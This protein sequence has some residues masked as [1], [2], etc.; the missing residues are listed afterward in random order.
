MKENVLLVKLIRLVM[1]ALFTA[2]FVVLER[3]LS[4]NVWNMRVGF[5]FLPLALT[6]TLYGPLSA[7]LVGA[8]GDVLG[9]ML[10]P[11]GPYFPGF[12]LTAAL[13]GAV[14][15]LFL[16][17]K[18]ALPQITAAVLINQIALSL[19]LQTLWISITYGASY[20]A[21]LPTR[22]IQCLIM[23]PVQFVVLLLLAKRVTGLAKR[24]QLVA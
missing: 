3:F 9:M 13:T 10:F 7:A 11:T 22:L 5:A 1:C 15:G 16:R 2:L 23:I 19:L 21:L 14:F 17:K 4:F 20:V 8:C 12:T 24:M 6:G 18:Q